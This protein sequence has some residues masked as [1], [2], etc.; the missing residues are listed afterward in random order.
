M[1]F[2]KSNLDGFLLDI[3]S[4][5]ASRSAW[6]RLALSGVYVIF[7]TLVVLKR[8]LQAGSTVDRR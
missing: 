7:I 6:E 3:A 2:V 5:I 1:L 4:I 8:L